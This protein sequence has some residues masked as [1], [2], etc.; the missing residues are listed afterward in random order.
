MTV[1]G[2]MVYTDDEIVTIIEDG[3]MIV[4]AVLMLVL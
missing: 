1:S 2:A 4:M 3:A